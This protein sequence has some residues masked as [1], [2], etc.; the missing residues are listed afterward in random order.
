MPSTSAKAPKAQ[1]TKIRKAISE[2]DIC[3]S[4]KRELQ[5]TTSMPLGF[6]PDQSMRSC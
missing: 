4:S 2:A 6:D 3:F 5:M 1:M